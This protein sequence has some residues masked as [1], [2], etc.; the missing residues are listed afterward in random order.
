[1]SRGVRVGITALGLRA[2]MIRGDGVG[3]GGEGGA[4]RVA[5]VVVVAGR[6]GGGCWWWWMIGRT[7][8]ETCKLALGMARLGDNQSSMSRESDQQAAVRDWH[9]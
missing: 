6:D 9:E 3:G 5:A 7:I 2:Q 1:M 8:E 4:A